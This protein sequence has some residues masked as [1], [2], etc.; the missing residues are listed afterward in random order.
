[1]GFRDLTPRQVAK[2]HRDGVINGCGNRF[3]VKVVKA[4]FRVNVLSFFY[5][6]RCDWHD[7]NYF[8][9]GDSAT[10]LR[11]DRGFFEAMQRDVK[12]LP[13]WKRPFAYAVARTYYHTVRMFGRSSFSYGKKMTKVETQNYLE[14]L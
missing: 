1:M 13:L 5:E 3:A 10:R 14:S 6:S 12:R 4:I 7:W 2:L 11:A 8:L 9:G